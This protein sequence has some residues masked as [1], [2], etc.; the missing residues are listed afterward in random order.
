MYREESRWSLLQIIFLMLFPF[1]QVSAGAYI[2]PV[3]FNP[4]SLQVTQQLLSWQEHEAEINP[5][6]QWQSCYV[7]FDVKYQKHLPTMYSSCEL[8]NHCI[9]I[10]QYRTRQE[11]MEAWRR[12]KGIPYSGR[13]TVHDTSAI[14]VGL[15]Y[16]ERPAPPT[17]NANHAVQFPGSVC[18]ELPPASQACHVILSAEIDFGV[19]NSRQIN[20]V[21]KEVNGALYCIREGTVTLRGQSLLGERNIW[22]DGERRNFYSTLSINQQ[23][24]AEGVSFKV[25]S[26]KPQSFTLSATLQ[27]AVIP[28]AG[29][30]T[31]NG[32]VFITYP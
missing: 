25:L 31:G 21:R 12:E 5:C 30:Y 23:D 2:F 7:G 8:S 15:F 9:R 24:A 20:G 18:S 14:C 11:V 4:V 32:I 22:F 27:A 3:V 1:R 26:N 28:E 19:L 13:F 17:A 6:Y 10:E 16:T 29:S